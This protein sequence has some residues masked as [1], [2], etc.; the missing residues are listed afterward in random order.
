M[1]RTVECLSCGK[2]FRRHSPSS[3][4]GACAKKNA[5]FGAFPLVIIQLIMYQLGGFLKILP[6]VQ[7]SKRHHS[8]LNLQL[9]NQL[10]GST[11][12]NWTEALI[13]LGQLLNIPLW[14]I[15]KQSHGITNSVKSSRLTFQ[16]SD[17]FFS[18]ATAYPV[19]EKTPVFQF[20]LLKSTRK[21]LKFG[22]STRKI[23]KFGCPTEG[24]SLEIYVDPELVWGTKIE[25]RF[26][27]SAL[28]GTG[29]AWQSED[30][31][32]PESLFN[33]PPPELPQLKGYCRPDFK[34][35]NGQ[36]Y[37]L[38]ANFQTGYLALS[39]NDIF[40]ATIPFDFVSKQMHFQVEL[41]GGTEI[42]IC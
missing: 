39:I 20:R 17:R 38:V 36:V 31:P 4:C 42:Q 25:T 40:I 6:L 24:K 18:T 14:K 33:F 28:L 11:I 2:E 32:I 8:A 15:D 27:D 30:L 34:V 1:P 13:Q 21:I 19:S 29:N 35:E 5:I 26:Y 7:T 10:I 3:Y 22:C 12:Q 37:K 41:P 23:F 16:G 9:V